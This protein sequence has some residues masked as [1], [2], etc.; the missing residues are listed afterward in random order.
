[1]WTDEEDEGRRIEGGILATRVAVI[2]S[3]MGGI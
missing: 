2:R 3:N 1:M